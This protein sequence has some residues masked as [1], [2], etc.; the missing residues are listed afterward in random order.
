MRAPQALWPELDAQGNLLV[1][2][3]FNHCIRRVSPAGMVT[4]V[5]GVGGDRADYAVRC[6]RT[7]FFLGVWPAAKNWSRGENVV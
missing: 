3:C 2:D 7:A 6:S 1:A 5:A 4:T